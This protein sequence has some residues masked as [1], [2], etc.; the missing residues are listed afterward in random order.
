LV[1]VTLLYP[2]AQAGT[3][4]LSLTGDTTIANVPASVPFNA[5]DTGVSVPVS[6][7]A[8]PF[9]I[10]DT[11]TVTASL[12]NALGFSSSASATFTI[13]GVIPLE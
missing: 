7:T 12:T 4:A 11:F 6:I 10:T 9:N 5:G 1:T 3:I 13:T 2:A 8:V